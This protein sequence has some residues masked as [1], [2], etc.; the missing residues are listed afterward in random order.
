MA[1]RRWAEIGASFRYSR[2]RWIYL[3]NFAFFL[4]MMAQIVIRQ[5]LAFRLTGSPFALGLI[6]LAVA[7][8][9][10]VVSPLGGVVA[11]RMD[12]RRLI[13]FGQIVLLTSEIA[14]FL[15]LITD[16]LSYWM[17]LTGVAVMG[18]VFPVMMPAR[19]AI[20]V[21]TVGREGLAN[22]MALQM[23][24][25]NTAR[26]V[27]PV[28]GG[29]L[30]AFVSIEGAFAASLVLYFIA[31]I[32]VYRVG[33][34]PV[35]GQTAGASWTKDMAEGFTFVWNGKLVR[36]L[37]IMAIVP[38]FLAMPFQ[39]LLV[40]FTEEEWGVGPTG[41]GI[42]QAFAGVGGLIGSF[43]MA[44]VGEP[45]RRLRL[46]AST[47]LAFTGSLFL[48]AL[49]PWFLI[50]L[51]LV[52]IADVFVAMFQT[53][54]ATAIQVLIPDAIRGRVMSVMMMTFGLT[55]MGTVPVAAV[56]EVWGAPIA[57]AGAA[58]I[59]G[60]ISIVILVF[61]GAIKTLDAEMEKGFPDSETS[62]AQLEP[63]EQVE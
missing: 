62:F 56:A 34:A 21:S 33:P 42:L 27:G 17:L 59:T 54:N 6:G 63:R 10:L 3:S 29:F 30:V 15:L 11:D 45:K 32:S 35:E 51:P 8:P 37:L 18:T 39:S 50:A 16:Q 41:F 23:G 40:V 46:M 28:M 31:L 60:T 36:V 7:I 47:L 26:I 61:N 5:I 4:A 58:A 48:F 1:D 12:R 9:M 57:I 55:P 38:A 14:V 49:S 22:A 25:M 43:I 53:A 24:G 2:F 13:V 19:Q 44:L 20:I 52:L